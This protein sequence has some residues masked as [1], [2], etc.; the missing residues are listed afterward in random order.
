MNSTANIAPR[1]LTKSHFKLAVE[2][3]TKLF[4]TGKSGIYADSKTTD[5][6][7]Q[8]LAE[9]GFQVGELAKLM[10]PGGSE[11]SERKH[12]IAVEQT[13]SRLAKTEVTL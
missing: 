1:Y 3:P 5:D 13:R 8:A 10:F 6:F 2:C 9:G 11:I 4:Y 7:L 12:E